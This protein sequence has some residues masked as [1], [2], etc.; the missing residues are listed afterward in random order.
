MVFTLIFQFVQLKLGS[1]LNSNIEYS[2]LKDSLDSKVMS[3]VVKLYLR[4][5]FDSS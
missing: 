4:M 3:V 5:T 2:N 1:D